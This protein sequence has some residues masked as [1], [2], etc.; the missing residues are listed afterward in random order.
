MLTSYV[1]KWTPTIEEPKVYYREVA[2]PTW[3][4]RAPHGLLALLEAGPEELD[5]D[6]F[7]L[8]AI[9]AMLDVSVR[10][11]NQFYDGT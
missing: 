4:K 5:S 6:K 7:A 8:G 1:A 10:T 9:F 2:D 3:G 11:K